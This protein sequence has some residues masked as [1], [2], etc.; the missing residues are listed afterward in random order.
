M[1]LN[2]HESRIYRQIPYAPSYAKALL[3]QGV[4]MA[5]VVP[6]IPGVTLGMAAFSQAGHPEPYGEAGM[7]LVRD[8]V[9]RAAVHIDN[10]RL[11]IRDHNTAVTLQRSL[12]PAALAGF[13]VTFVNGLRVAAKTNPDECTLIQRMEAALTVLD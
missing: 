10:A 8:L 2:D 11:H 7:R 3:A 12:L 4:H 6:L 1:V 13:F 9:S 5:M